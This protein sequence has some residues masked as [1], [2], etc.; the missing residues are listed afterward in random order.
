[1]LVALEQCSGRFLLG[2]DV[3]IRAHDSYRFPRRIPPHKCIAAEVADGSIGPYD[4]EL[5]VELHFSSYSCIEFLFRPDTV[6][7]VHQMPKRL[8]ITA[9]L[10]LRGAEE[11]EHLF[12]PVQY[13]IHIVEV[14]NARASR[15]CRQSQPV[16][17]LLQKFFRSLLGGDI[18]I[19]ADH[20]H[21]FAVG[22]ALNLGQS[23]DIVDAAVRPNH[24]KLGVEFLFAAQGRIALPHNSFPVFRMQPARPILESMAELILCGSVK[25]KH[26]LVPNQGAAR[27]V[28]I[29]NAHGARARC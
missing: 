9:E 26:L 29:P 18:P 15:A 1:M 28:P 2:S 11:A 4:A 10:V 16:R 14:P 12:V 23:P 27:N 8:E 21:W 24:S 17:G 22:I 3:P 25:A 6:F 5:D 7:R 20:A 19:G 13:T